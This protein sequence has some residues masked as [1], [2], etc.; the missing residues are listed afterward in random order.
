[1]I[2]FTYEF[3]LIPFKLSWVIIDEAYAHIHFESILNILSFR[4]SWTH[5]GYWIHF[6][7]HI[8]TKDL[9]VLQKDTNQ[10]PKCGIGHPTCS[11]YL[12]F[13]M[14]TCLIKVNYK[15]TMI[16]DGI[17]LAPCSQSHLT[18]ATII[19]VDNITNETSEI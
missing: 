6:V 4:L 15:T 19:H 10:S 17:L 9:L 13:V 2:S 16:I 5:F 8:P 1:M 14:C 18:D 3:R 11:L 7:S 12:N